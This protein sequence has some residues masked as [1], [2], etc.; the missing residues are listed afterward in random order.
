MTDFTH[1]I[2]LITGAA[3]GTGRRLAEALAGRGAVVAAVDINPLG[4]D[5][6]VRRIRAAGG[7]VKD[8]VFD[9]AKR[10]PVVALVDAVLD[11]WGRIDILVLAAEVHPRDP[12]L[13]MD[14]WDFYRTLD[15][16]LAGPFFLMQRAAQAMKSQGGGTI[17][18]AGGGEAKPAGL[19]QPD[20]KAGTGAAYRISKAGL[21]AL[22]QAA[23]AEFRAYNI[24][25]K[26]IADLRW[27]Y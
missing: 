3:G 8:Y 4:L 25:V 7:T 2:A 5:E 27:N 18:I 9:A 10:L 16:N 26:G 12:I 14:E 23:Q 21:A 20:G 19:A 11:D 15:V 17:L 6:T 13:S 24:Q 22:A 1:K